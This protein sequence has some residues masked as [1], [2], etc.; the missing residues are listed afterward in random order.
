[1][2]SPDNPG[3]GELAD[4]MLNLEGVHH[5]LTHKFDPNDGGVCA[6]TIK[7]VIGQ[8]AALRAR[9]AEEREG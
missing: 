4:M 8:L 5:D 3:I 2:S 1:M 9:I 6:G 7:R